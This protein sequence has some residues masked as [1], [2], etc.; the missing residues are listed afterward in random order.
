MIGRKALI[1]SGVLFLIFGSNVVL[2]SMGGP[3]FLG[4]LGELWMMILS[5]VFFV[6][7][8]IHEENKAKKENQENAAANGQGQSEFS[9]QGG[10][11]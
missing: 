11:K 8:I 4:D 1:C 3:Q 6:I 7:A 5:V 2:G 10:T 9:K